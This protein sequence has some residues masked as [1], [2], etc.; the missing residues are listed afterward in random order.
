MRDF[1]LKR[2]KRRE[3]RQQK[4]VSDQLQPG[5]SSNQLQTGQLPITASLSTAP[6]G[7]A[8]MKEPTMVLPPWLC[9]TKAQHKLDKQLIK[10]C[11][12]LSTYQ[13]PQPQQPVK[14]PPVKAP[15]VKALQGAP[16][17]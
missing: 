5:S 16:A 13:D 12:P 1:K 9:S 15:P 3:Q 4:T 8:S 14:A 11:A 17:C 7:T 6:S 2:E 10:I